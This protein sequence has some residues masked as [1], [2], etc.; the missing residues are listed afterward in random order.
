[1]LVTYGDRVLIVDAETAELRPFVGSVGEVVSVFYTFH[2][3][4]ATVL[5]KPNV[6]IRINVRCLEVI[7]PSTSPFKHNDWV[8]VKDSY[9]DTYRSIPH[10]CIKSMVGKVGQVKG[11]DKRAGFYL[12]KSGDGDKGWFPDTSLVPTEYKGA[13]FYYPLEKVTYKGEIKTITQVQISKGRYGQILKI[14][15]EWIPSSDVTPES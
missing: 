1:M 14:D 10:K 6:E 5:I 15:G 4:S 11:Y 8:K 7:P 9:I 3:A 12:V 13:R 2:P